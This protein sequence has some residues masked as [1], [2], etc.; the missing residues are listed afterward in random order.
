MLGAETGNRD[1]LAAQFHPAVIH[2]LIDDHKVGWIRL[3]LQRGMVADARAERNRLSITCSG[4]QEYVFQ[5][6]APNI[7]AEAVQR[8]LWQLPGL[9]VRVNTKANGPTV[10]HAAEL[11]ELRYGVSDSSAEFILTIEE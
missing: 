3:R 9:K 11:V 1:Y 10:T 4:S 6:A 2:W 7:G 8:D 5:I